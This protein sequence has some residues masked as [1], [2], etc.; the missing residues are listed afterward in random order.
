MRS[1][2]FSIFQ[3]SEGEERRTYWAMMTKGGRREGTLI[4]GS[5]LLELGMR[6]KAS[7]FDGK[8][9]CLCDTLRSFD[10]A[11]RL[12]AANGWTERKTA[13]FGAPRLLAPPKRN[14]KESTVGKNPRE[15]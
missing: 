11:E 9:A 5:V 3:R 1:T 6:E 2:D 7:A 10:I 14:L 8:S 13:L 12:P 4:G 15:L